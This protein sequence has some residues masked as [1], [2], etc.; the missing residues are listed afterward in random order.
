MSSPVTGQGRPSFVWAVPAFL[1]FAFFAIVP[2]IVVVWLSFTSWDALTAPTWIGLD[3]W[4]RLGSDPILM[5]SIRV[6]LGLTAF[7]WLIQT[8]IALPLGVWLARPGR[9]RATVGA[10]LFIPLLISSAGIGVLWGMLLDPNF[11]M[12]A[13]VGPWI[14]VTDG[15]FIGDPKLA[16][17]VLVFVGSWQFVPFHALLYQGATRQ[18]PASLYEAAQLDGASY[19]QQ[20]R[21]ITIPQ[22]KHTIVTSSVLMI[23]GSLTYFD[24]V[25]ILTDGGPGTATTTLPLHMYKQ[26]FRAFDFGYASVLAVILLVLGTTLSVVLTRMTGFAKMESQREGL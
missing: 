1:F 13:I 7:S 9:S 11:G 2:M 26:G 25:L 22:L 14:G 21:A 8:L 4:A 23:V 6:T 3:N 19:L 17:W 18:I 16:F 20:F 15:N 5:E 24:L 12:A 10:V